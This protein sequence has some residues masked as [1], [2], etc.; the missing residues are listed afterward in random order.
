MLETF[1][2]HKFWLGALVGIVAWHFIGPMV[3][4]AISPKAQS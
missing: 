3:M 2:G 1:R 4:G